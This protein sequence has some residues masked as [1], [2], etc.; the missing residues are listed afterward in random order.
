MTIAGTLCLL[1]LTLYGSSFAKF[2]RRRTLVTVIALSLSGAISLFLFSY[3]REVC[4]QPWHTVLPRDVKP[5]RDTVYFPLFLSP[6]L[7]KLVF[8]SETPDRKGRNEV[9]DFIGPDRVRQII[10]RD[11]AYLTATSAIFLG[12]YMVMQL[13]T[14]SSFT[15]LGYRVSA[16]ES[17]NTGA[18]HKIDRNRPE[19]R[20]LAL[21]PKAA[22]VT[23]VITSSEQNNSER[24]EQP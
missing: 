9:L 15:I 16:L 7:R 2:S 23:P 6:D 13:S 4:V 21:R 22:V 11:P 12:L 19:K 24:A 10:S 17:H 20:F 5:L 14:V 3:A 18:S 8:R 1:L